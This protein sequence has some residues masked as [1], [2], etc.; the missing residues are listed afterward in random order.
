ML[1]ISTGSRN[2]LTSGYS[3]FT[4]SQL[5]FGSQFWPENSQTNSQDMSVSSRNS[6]QSSQE[7]SDPKFLNSY[8]LKPLLFGD[9]NGLPQFEEDKRR[10]KEKADGDILAKECQ[11]FREALNNVHQLVAGTEKNTAVCQTVVDKIDDFTSTIQTK[12]NS[13]QSDI[14]HQFETLLNKAASQK[15]VLIDLEERVQKHDSASANLCSNLQSLKN[16]L[17]CLKEEQMREQKMVE[18][19]VTL[20]STLVSEQSAKPTSVRLMDNAIQTSPGLE[21]P[22]QNNLQGKKLKS[23]LASI[24]NNLEQDKP[25][26]PRRGQSSIRG[27]RKLTLKKHRR[28]KKSPPVLSGRRKHAVTDENTQPLMETETVKDGLTQGNL[29]PPKTAIRSLATGCLISPRSCWSQDSNS[30]A[31]LLE[32]EPEKLSAK[33]R[34]ATPS[35]TGGLWQLFD[36]DE[37]AEVLVIE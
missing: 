13:L 25:E 1:S 35:K 14:S 6:Q 2:T 23:T 34:A 12:L 26:V 18:E 28:T 32:I 19:A 17:Q 21:P 22:F 29:K 31:C 11:T 5:F 15:E 16:D 24:S 9:L 7:E 3:S 33:S 37:D 20:L 30:S 8:H 4:D 36:T 27:S 10:A